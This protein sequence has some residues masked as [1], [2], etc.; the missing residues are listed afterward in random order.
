[1]GIDHRRLDILVPQQVLDG[2]DVVIILQQIGKKRSIGINHGRL[3]YALEKNNMHEEAKIEWEKSSI[4]IEQPDIEK[5][6]Q[7][8]ENINKT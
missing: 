5:L 6:K 7:L 4:M 8:I 3:A 2:P 1:M